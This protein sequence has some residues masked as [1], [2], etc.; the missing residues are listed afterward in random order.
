MT[1]V[2]KGVKIAFKAAKGAFIGG[3]AVVKIGMAVAT[4]VAA[5][6]L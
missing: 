1:A 5:K 2:Y 3:K 6:K 4:V